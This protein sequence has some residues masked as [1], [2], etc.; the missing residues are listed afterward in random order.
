MLSGPWVP[1]DTPLRTALY[2]NEEGYGGLRHAQI[3]FCLAVAT[4]STC[5]W[6]IQHFWCEKC[7][8][9]VSRLLYND[10]VHDGEIH[11]T[12]KIEKGLNR[13]S[14][15][16]MS[17]EQAKFI[18]MSSGTGRKTTLEWEDCRE[19]SY[20]QKAK[21]GRQVMGVLGNGSGILTQQTL[22][23]NTVWSGWSQ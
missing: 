16:S 23:D 20:I 14:F 2:F 8:L 22:L 6:W 11:L 17:P 5:V 10:N 7:I 21:D 12:Y 15:W 13:E 1:E 18:F 3:T 9:I 4:T 19:H